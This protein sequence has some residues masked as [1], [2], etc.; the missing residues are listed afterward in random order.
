M[1]IKTRSSFFYGHIVTETNRNID[2]KEG[3]NPFTA[4]LDAKAYSLSEYIVEIERAMNIAG[5]QEYNVSVDRLTRKISIS[6]SLAFDLLPA[7]GP[8]FGTSAYPMMGFTNIDLTGI[9][10]YEGDSASGYEYRPQFFLQNYIDF[11]DWQDSSKSSVS[12][13]AEG[14]VQV[15]S[16]GVVKFMSCNI[17][18]ISDLF[19]SSD[20]FIENNQNAVAE[21]RA[22]LVNVVQK[23]SIEF[24]PDRDSPETFTKCILE[25]TAISKSG[26]GF[27]LYELIGKQLNERFETKKLKFRKVT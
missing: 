2:F 18:Y 26:T 8:T 13:S 20:G 6:A 10:A 17:N 15:T 11:E 27:R 14:L 3:L 22:F 24:I 4:T 25:A 12:E 1:T 23:G 16:F 5:D 21:A 7:T 19:H 9:T